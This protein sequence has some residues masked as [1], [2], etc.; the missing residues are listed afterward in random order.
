MSRD[1]E[2]LEAY[3]REVLENIDLPSVISTHFSVGYMVPVDL[4]CKLCDE[5]ESII[6]I[7]CS[8][9]EDLVYLV[10]LL[11]EL[12]SHVEVHVGGPMHT[13]SAL[14]MGA[15]GFLS[16]EG[17]LAPRLAKSLIDK[18][19]TGDYR[20]AEEAYAK[21]MLLFSLA[22]QGLSGGKALAMSLG[23]PVGYP[24]RP[25][26]VLVMSPCLT[27]ASRSSFFTS[28]LMSFRK[29]APPGLASSAQRIKVW[30]SVRATLYLRC[31]RSAQMNQ[32]ANFFEGFFDVLRDLIVCQA[33]HR[34]T[35][36]GQLIVAMP[37]IYEG[38]A[39]AVAAVPVKFHN[40]PAFFP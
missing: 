23:L 28:G 1:D 33:Q 13:M 30:I 14:A 11:D 9:R 17:N 20:G 5:Y 12:P 19:A 24:R 37:V 35:A 40:E 7:N 8:V 32:V 36:Q 4:L 25:R 10:R 39:I 38:F 31:T 18:Y 22:M 34:K 3:F 6:G 2:E 26:L 15:T 16:S 27:S 29:L 21:I